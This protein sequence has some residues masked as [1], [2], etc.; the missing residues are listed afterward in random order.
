MLHDDKP[1]HKLKGRFARLAPN[2]DTELLA[3]KGAFGPWHKYLQGRLF[4]QRWPGEKVSDRKSGRFG[5]DWCF[6]R[7]C[8]E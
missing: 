8:V 4:L 3:S 5:M 2:N 7:F 1:A 6:V